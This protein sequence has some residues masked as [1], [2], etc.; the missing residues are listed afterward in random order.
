MELRRRVH[1]G[2]NK[3]KARKELARTV[4]FNRFGEIRNRSFEQ[5]RYQAKCP[6]D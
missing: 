3:G 2:L 6:K 4:F 1:A 5:Q